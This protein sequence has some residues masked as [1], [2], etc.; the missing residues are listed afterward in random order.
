M[1]TGDSLGGKLGTRLA[2]VVSRAM[3][4]HRQ[5]AR[6]ELVR[7]G[8]TMQEEFFRLTGGEV[9]GTIGP[10]FQ[11]VSDHP[12]APDWF[13][14]T[15]AFIAA[16]KG[17]WA[18]L[19]AGAATGALMGTGLLDVFTNW[20]RPAIGE[21][22]R[23]APNTPLSPADAAAAQLRGLSWGP[24]LW[25]DAA[26]AGVNEDRFRILMSLQSNTLQITEILELLNRKEIDATLAAKLFKRAGWTDEQL[27][28]LFH[29]RHTILSIQ[30][31]AAMWNRDIVS[32]EDGRRIAEMN[33]YAA[34]D[35][36]RFAALGG[37]PPDMT[38]LIL[39]WQRGV[40]TESDV[41]RALI[42]GPL[43]KEWIPVIKN[44]RYGPLGPGEVADAV[45]QGHMEFSAA[46]SIAAQSGVRPEDF[47]V[48]VDNAGLP[49]G[50]QEALDWLRRGLITEQQFRE[51]FLE[52][53]LKNKYIQL[54]LDSLPILLTRTEIT[55][56]YSKGAMDRPQATERLLQLGYSPENAAI[57]LTG[58]S[59]EKTTAE[60]D[61]TKSELLELYSDQAITAEELIAAL[62]SMGYSDDEAGQYVA[63]ADLRRFRRFW[64]AAVS[65]VKSSYV[66]RRLDVNEA[67]SALDALNVPPAARDDYLALWD[68]ERGVVTK[69]LTT[70]QVVAAA[71]AG[72]FD[73]NTAT[74]RLMGQGYD[75]ADAIV[76]LKLGK[77][78]DV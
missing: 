70:A 65:R 38:A 17:Q 26:Q 54:Y 68:I 9:A 67:S 52:S 74:N 45:N 53:R 36:D 2:D 75:N 55:S 78:I 63:L 58:A 28:F 72:I 24:N 39:A 71:K 73:V 4:D 27:S 34:D 8:M 19:A 44:M 32:T 77:A 29:L 11:V 25:T 62:G 42:Q 76:L 22:I 47:Q 43:R 56:L 49:P 7:L 1:A 20:M 61:L 31:A 33:G 3:I 5:R 18:T 37:E 6:P 60:R 21:L 30:D 46:Q 64:N 69:E 16:G 10:F 15:G 35:F 48:I 66:T 41:D 23:E 40:I 13:K 14:R 50:P 12:D 59:H 51:A 57:I